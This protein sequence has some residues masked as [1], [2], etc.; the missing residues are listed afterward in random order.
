[1]A[2]FSE[3]SNLINSSPIR[4]AYKRPWT[5]SA[6]VQ[7][8]ACHLN[9]ATPLSE[10]V[11]TYC[12]L[13]PKEHISMKFYNWNSNVFIQE[14]GFEH[15]VCKMAAMLSR[16]R[17]VNTVRKSHCWYIRRWAYGFCHKTCAW[18]CRGLFCCEYIVAS[19]KLTWFI[20]GYIPLRKT[21]HL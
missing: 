16:G 13:D 9:G 5:G 21:R 20:V 6:L 15:V 7:I 2:H 14:N 4:T 12:Q 18:C 3:W 19:Y 11:W 8:M 17:W 10:P 1:M